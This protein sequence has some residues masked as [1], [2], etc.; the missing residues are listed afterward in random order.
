MATILVVD[1]RAINRQLLVTLLGYRDHRV[2]EASDGLEALELLRKEQVD[3]VITD[4][5]MPRL[6]GAELAKRIRAGE[7]TSSIPVVFYTATYRAREARLMAQECG[8]EFVLAKPSAPEA[9]MRVVSIA[10]GEQ[11]A[12]AVAPAA[13]RPA[14]PSRGRRRARSSSS[15]SRPAPP[16]GGNG[17]SQ[18]L[19]SR[20]AAVVELSLDAA[21]ENNPQQLLALFARAAQNILSAKLVGLAVLSDDGSAIEHCFVK[22]RKRGLALWFEGSTPPGGVLAELVADGRPRR[23][24][25]LGGD[26][27]RIGLP[28][29]HPALQTFLGVPVRSPTRTQ[30]WLYA[31]DRVDGSAFDESDERLAVTIAAQIGLVYDNVRLRDAVER[32]AGELTQ[33]H[34]ELQ[35]FAYSVS[36]DLKDPLREIRRLTAFLSDDCAALLDD[37]GREYLQALDDTAR[38]MARLIDGLMELSRLSLQPSSPSATDVV[39]IVLE[40]IERLRPGIE[41]VGAEAVVRGVAPKVFADR[42]KIEQIFANLISNALKFTKAGSPLVEIGV[43]R[44]TSA[45]A[46]F[47]VRDN[48]I[49]IASEHHERIFGLFDRLHPR[50]EYEGTGAGL[51]IVQRAVDLLGGRV[52]LESRPGVGTTFYVALPVVVGPGQGETEREAEASEAA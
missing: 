17:D 23:L 34:E 31:A 40:M 12:A 51:A 44:V 42:S 46:V 43:D 37:Q 35:T 50:E 27:K 49:G 15:T 8:V 13:A 25:D 19:L 36:H 1:D 45:T 18:R 32:G 21:L 6:D 38:F 29:D 16:V 2:L 4:I 52:W 39:A 3:L 24:C 47:Y 33:R 22:G 11:P 20:L 14:A 48:G 41:E 28:A 10:L 26:P 30:G 9:I 7:Q 5:M